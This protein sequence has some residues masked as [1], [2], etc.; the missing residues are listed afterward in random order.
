MK[1]LLAICLLAAPMFA[2]D[3]GTLTDGERA[4]LLEQL[5]KSRKD[6][7]SSIQ[8]MSDAQ[9]RYKPAPNVWSVAECAEHIVISED[10]LFNTAKQILQTPAVDRPESSNAEQD[11][12]LAVMVADRSHKATAPEPLVPSGKINSP[13]DAI[14]EFTAKRDRNIEYV[15]S[16]QDDLRVHATKGPLGT[17]DSYQ[18]LVLMA[19]HT[20]RHTAQI[21]EV[22]GNA[23]YPK[24]S[25][26]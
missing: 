23:E 21:R 8:G 18:F 3:A 13:A 25:A 20:G 4:F 22:Q 1:K 9:W 26:E 7:L 12:K 19:V 11:K 6:F 17:M 24:G 16:T 10:F 14:R 15:K 2:A 5:Q